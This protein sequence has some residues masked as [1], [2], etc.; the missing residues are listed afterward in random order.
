MPLTILWCHDTRV[1]DLS[2]L[3][4][5]P[6]ETLLCSNTPV[7]NLSPLAGMPL[8]RLECFYTKVS[9]LSP[10]QGMNITDLAISPKNITKGMDAVRQMRGLKTI[11]TDAANKWPPDKFWKKYDAGEFGKPVTTLNDPAFQ[12]W[13]TA[14]AT[15]PA[16]QQVEAVAKKLQELNPGFDGKET[17]AIEGDVV[18]GLFFVTD[19]VADISPVRALV[20]L[21][22]LTIKGSSWDVKGKVSDLSPLK[23]LQLTHLYCSDTQVSD[24]SPLKGMPLDQLFCEGTLVSDLSQLGGIPLTSLWFD[25]TAVSDL[26]PLKGMSFTDLVFYDGN[27]PVSDL[28]PLRGMPLKSLD[29]SGTRVADLSPLLG[30]KLEYLHCANTAVAD[31]SLLKGMPLIS[32]RCGAERRYPDLSPLEGMSIA[33]LSFLR[34]PRSR[35][36]SMPSAK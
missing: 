4:G 17:H 1:A 32:L 8:T 33:K 23:G 7:A 28:S 26:S 20:G 6:L 5:M 16:E 36:G 3:K 25:R 10:L 9:D 22:K 35:R 19:E 21:K 14:V 13:L 18:T 34:P 31:L 29:L 27:T 11:A 12:K 15:M 30:M 2:P 24:L